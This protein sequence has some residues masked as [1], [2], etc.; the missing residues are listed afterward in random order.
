MVRTWGIALGAF[1]GSC[2]IDVAGLQSVGLAVAVI[3]VA[4][5]AAAAFFGE[6]RRTRHLSSYEYLPFKTMNT[7]QLRSL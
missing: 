4:A 5:I 7:S 3:I 2:A 6:T 1:I